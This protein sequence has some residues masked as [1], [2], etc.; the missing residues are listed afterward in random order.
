MWMSK[1]KFPAIWN[2]P[3]QMIK[4]W[5]DLDPFFSFWEGDYMADVRVV[6]DSKILDIDTNGAASVKVLGPNGIPVNV[7]ADGKLSVDAQVTASVADSKIKGSTDAGITW[8]PVKVDAEGNLSVLLNGRNAQIIATLLTTTPLGAN[9]SFIQSPA[10]QVDSALVNGFSPMAVAALIVADAPGVLEVRCRAA[11]SPSKLQDAIYVQGNA[12]LPVLLPW[13]PIAAAE[14][15]FQYNNYA[16]PQSTFRLVQFLAAVPILEDLYVQ[17]I[18]LDGGTITIPASGTWTSRWFSVP[19]VSR[20]ALNIKTP[21]STD[22]HNV[23]VMWA[24][25]PNVLAIVH[26]HELTKT[27]EGTFSDYYAYNDRTYAPYV[28]VQITNGSQ[29]ERTFTA[30]AYG[31]PR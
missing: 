8:I 22:Q 29:A 3:S 18:P 19:R 30:F 24:Y 13:Q 12:L 2:H 26:V 23:W 10:V 9:A 4:G 25:E 5:T 15:W 17:T 11:G 1:E 7:T 20:F 21:R 16:T 31:Y 6:K 28:Q 14:M 27:Q